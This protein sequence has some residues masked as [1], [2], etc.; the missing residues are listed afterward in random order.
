[1]IHLLFF[2][3]KCILFAPLYILFFAKNKMYNVKICTGAV[4]IGDITV[5]DNVTIGAGSI[6]VKSIPDNCIVCGNPAR[7]INRNGE[8]INIKL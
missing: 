3:V 1:M 7:I 4:V 2:S 8:K 6:V 5:G